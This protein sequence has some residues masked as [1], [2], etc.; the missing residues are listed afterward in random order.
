MNRRNGPIEPA[1]LLIFL[2]AR[3]HRL[4]LLASVAAGRSAGGPQ[5]ADHRHR[6]AQ[7]VER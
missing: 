7:E 2:S 5:V 1:A 4:A 6:P 3:L